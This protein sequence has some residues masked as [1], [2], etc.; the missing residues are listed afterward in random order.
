MAYTIIIIILLLIILSSISTIDDQIEYY[1]NF[2]LYPLM[3]TSK[4]LTIDSESIVSKADMISR[5][6]DS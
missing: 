1:G 4:V 5:M 3:S 6:V 2:E